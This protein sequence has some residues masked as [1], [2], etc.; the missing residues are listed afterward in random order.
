M[1]RAE[2]AQIRKEGVA[3]DR[4]ELSVGLICVAA[5]VFDVMNQ[6]LAALSVSGRNGRYDPRTLAGT[7]REVCN[8]A[9]KAYAARRRSERKATNNPPVSSSGTENT[10]QV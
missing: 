9:T 1:L 2:L 6:P 3:Y 7:L 8:E 5:P 10:A 4:M